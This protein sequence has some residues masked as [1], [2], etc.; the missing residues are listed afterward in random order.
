[1]V[2][3]AE[4]LLVSLKLAREAGLEI[5]G[6]PNIAPP[7]GLGAVVDEAR[8]FQPTK[9]GCDAPRALRQLGLLAVSPLEASGRG[10]GGFWEQRW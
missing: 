7:R 1:M 8:A 10:L 3:G 6:N 2:L 4:N 5:T 9:E